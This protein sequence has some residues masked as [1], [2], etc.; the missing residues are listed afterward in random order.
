MLGPNVL[1]TPVLEPQADTVNGVFPGV[2]D[3]TVWYDW[4]T[5]ARVDAQAGVNTSI[6]APLGHIPVYLRGGSVTPL[7]EPGYT[8]A[9]SRKNPWGLVVALSGE[10]KASGSLYVDD[11][12]SIEQEAT[13]NVCF[14][15]EECELSAK[16][17][18]KYED[19]NV[20]GSVK[21]LGVWGGVGEVKLN[22]EKVG[23][24]C[25]EYDEKEGV[26]V[27]KGLNDVTKSGAWKG[28]W[29]LSWGK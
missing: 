8:T 18:G 1:V 14:E 16:V 6:S 26:L 12:E 21:V 3:G 24:G 2:A 25:V 11:G 19:T 29:T 9:E 4:Y 10:G 7:Q 22:G 28:D 17:E 15:V 20:L 23:E 27:V 13:L 5:G